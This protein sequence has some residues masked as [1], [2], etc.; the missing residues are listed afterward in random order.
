MH[1][2]WFV[3]L[4]LNA[5]YVFFFPN[6]KPQN[7]EINP[8]FVSFSQ[9][10]W[11]LQKLL[12]GFH[13]ADRHGVQHLLP[14]VFWPPSKQTFWLTS[15]DLQMF[16]HRLTFVWFSVRSSSP[17]TTSCG[18]GWRSTQWWTSSRFPRCLYQCTWTGVGLVRLSILWHFFFFFFTPQPVAPPGGRSGSLQISWSA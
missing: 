17:P 11:V 8:F 9:P 4:L 1:L 13:A 3:F 16:I 14:A 5:F 15:S 6:L 18:S 2:L 7:V 10:H 12:F